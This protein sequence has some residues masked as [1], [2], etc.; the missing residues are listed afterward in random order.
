FWIKDRESPVESESLPADANVVL[1]TELRNTAL[2]Q[3]ASASQGS[4]PYD[5]DVLYQFW[6]HFLIRNFNTSMYN[7]FRQLAHDDSSQRSSSVG[8]SNLLK[9]YSEALSSQ[10][11]IRERIARHYVELVAAESA[12]NGRPAFKQLRA[13]WRNGALNVKNRKKINMFI[14]ASLRTS[15]EQ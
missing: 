3:R 14:D 4:C 8:M 1:Y 10:S 9:Y 11:D 2:K 15:L 12:D 6:S 13:A 5:L 7:E